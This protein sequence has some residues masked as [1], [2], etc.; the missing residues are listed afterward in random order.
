MKRP[1]EI[2]LIC[3][4]FYARVRGGEGGREAAEIAKKIRIGEFKL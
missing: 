3:L 1:T 4:D 2:I